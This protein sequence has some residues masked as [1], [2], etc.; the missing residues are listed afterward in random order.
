MYSICVTIAL[1]IWNIKSK[2]KVYKIKDS[3]LNL[4]IHILS[5]KN[6]GWTPTIRLTRQHIL[7]M[8]LQQ[9][10]L[11]SLLSWQECR[12]LEEPCIWRWNLSTLCI[13]KAPQQENMGINSHRCGHAV[14]RMITG[15]SSECWKGQGWLHFWWNGRKPHG[16]STDLNWSPALP[17]IGWVT[18]GISLQNGQ[19]SQWKERLWAPWRSNSIRYMRLSSHCAATGSPIHMDIVPGLRV[20]GCHNNDRTIGLL[21]WR[22]QWSQV[23]E[24][25]GYG[26]SWK[27]QAPFYLV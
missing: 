17:L 5:H 20:G 4:T 25:T 26:Q 3:I 14:V 10:S 2:P 6:T 19:F 18:R 9:A 13:H 12:P 11:G 21:S 8:S 16:K 22:P 7:P 24:C 1:G 15:V 23:P 27:L